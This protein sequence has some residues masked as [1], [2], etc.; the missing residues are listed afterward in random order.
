MSDNDKL[1]Y[2]LSVLRERAN[3]LLN[4]GLDVVLKEHPEMSKLLDFDTQKNKERIEALQWGTDK[5]C[6][7]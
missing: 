4:S 1:K 6:K 2:C 7:E 3:D 5:L